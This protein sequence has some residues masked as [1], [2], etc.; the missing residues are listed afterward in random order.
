M[1]PPALCILPD[2]F[3]D[4]NLRTGLAS[5]HRLLTFESAPRKEADATPP[6]PPT[7][8]PRS[9]NPSAPAARTVGDAGGAGGRLG[10]DPGVRRLE[11]GRGVGRRRAG[12]GR[13]VL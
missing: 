13:P 12:R 4:S 3:L 7:D 2:T 5:S 6:L 1:G 11:R 8:S 10:V 9:S